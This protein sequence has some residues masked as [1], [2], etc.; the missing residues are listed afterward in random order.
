MPPGTLH[1]LVGLREAWNSVAALAMK[2][3]LLA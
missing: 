1:T 2:F 3:Y